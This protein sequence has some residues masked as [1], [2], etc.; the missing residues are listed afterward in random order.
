MAIAPADIEANVHNIHTPIEELLVMQTNFSSRNNSTNYGRQA[1][2]GGYRGGNRQNNNTSGKKYADGTKRP[3]RVDSKTWRKIKQDD[4]Q[5]WDNI[6]DHGK[7]NFLLFGAEHPNTVK[8]LFD[9]QEYTVNNHAV[10]F[11]DIALEDIPEEDKGGTLK[12]LLMTPPKRRSHSPLA[13]PFHQER[14]PPCT[15][16]PGP[17]NSM[18]VPPIGRSTSKQD[19]GPIDIN[20]IL[21]HAPSKQPKGAPRH[22]NYHDFDPDGR[23]EQ[24]VYEINVMNFDLVLESEEPDA[25][26]VPA[27]STTPATQGHHLNLLLRR[28]HHLRG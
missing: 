8:K 21:S 9:S 18:T 27:A 11:A 24:T 1:N 25:T 22:V 12:Y 5:H 19:S 20:M 13:Q 28:H 3:V 2:L 26:I 7:A 15:L 16:A 6:S 10:E 23:S 17:S 4:R 14:T